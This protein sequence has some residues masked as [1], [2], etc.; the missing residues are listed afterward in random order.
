MKMKTMIRKAN[1]NVQLQGFLVKI[2]D[3]HH[4]IQIRLLF[5]LSKC[6]TYRHPEGE[7]TDSETGTKIK[8]DSAHGCAFATASGS[9]QHSRGSW[10]VF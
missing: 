7:R 2:L 8:N 1:N 9:L 4:I 5:N 3:V 10:R 6:F